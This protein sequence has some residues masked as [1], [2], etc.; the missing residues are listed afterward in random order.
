MVNLTFM[1]GNKLTNTN[2][3]AVFRALTPIDSAIIASFI[4]I[5][6]LTIVKLIGCII[7][8]GGTVLYGYE[9]TNGD[10]TTK[11]I[12]GYCCLFS[13]GIFNAFALIFLKKSY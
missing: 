10:F 1:I 12:I 13:E 11:E 5:E 8:G 4:G 9:D 7:T 2:S 3:T 6:K